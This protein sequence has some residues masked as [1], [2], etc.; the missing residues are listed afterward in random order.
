MMCSLFVKYFFS[1][2]INGRIRK[3]LLFS[4]RFLIPLPCILLGKIISTRPCLLFS[5]GNPTWGGR[6]CCVWLPSEWTN[7]RKQRRDCEANNNNNNGNL[8][9]THARLGAFTF[10]E[11]I[12]FWSPRSAMVEVHSKPHKMT[13]PVQTEAKNKDK[14]PKGEWLVL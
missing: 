10:K 7:G 11:V 5:F 13:S 12:Y 8:V 2:Q 14:T 1:T 3:S 9:F 4:V 6:I